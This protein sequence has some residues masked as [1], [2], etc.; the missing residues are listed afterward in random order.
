MTILTV[1]EFNAAIKRILDETTSSVAVQGELSDLAIRRGTLAFFTLKDADG[2]ASVKCFHVMTGDHFPVEEGMEVQ[3]TGRPSVFLRNAGFHLRVTAIEP[4]GEGAFRKMFEKLK[5]KLETE[6]LFA[7]EHKRPIPRFP[8]VIGLITSPDADAKSDVLRILKN[9]WAGFAVKLFP[10]AVQGRTAAAQ[11]VSAIGK[12]NRTPGIDVAILTR[13]GGSLE[14]LQA[15]NT[16]EVARAV[17]A[18]KVPVVTGV[19]HEADS[20]IADLVAD[21]RASTPSNAAER[22]VPD[23][24]AVR[25]EVE[26]FIRHLVQGVEQRVAELTS[27]VDTCV[28]TIEGHVDDRVYAV[29]STTERLQSSWSIFG[30]RLVRLRTDCLRAGDR[31]AMA[32]SAVV[33][34]QQTTVADRERMLSSLNPMNVL[35]RGYSVTYDEQ[36]RAV[37]EGIDVAPGQSI[38]TRLHKGSIRSTVQENQ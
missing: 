32:L 12:L 14:D 1:R 21:V 37:T 2:D 9:R 34:Q 35:K 7:E 20:T 29:R 28:R 13:G 16:E 5:A 4:V 30:E 23:R 27:D 33:R 36:G 17:Y 11:I 38:T 31:V 22:V 18:S 25:H 6:G 3:V 15:F 8:K 10:T 26:M 19:G 24:A